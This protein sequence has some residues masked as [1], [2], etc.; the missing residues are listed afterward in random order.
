[1]VV[2]DGGSR[3][4]R[5]GDE[6]EGEA[7]SAHDCC[8]TAMRSALGAAENRRAVVVGVS[9][10]LSRGQQKAK[11]AL[12]QS[13]SES[14]TLLTRNSEL[15]KQIQALGNELKE[16]RKQAHRS[17]DLD[18]PQREETSPRPT[19]RSVGST[20][21]EMQ[22]IENQRLRENLLFFTAVKPRGT[23]SAAGMSLTMP[24]PPV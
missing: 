19:M 11:S 2:R 24:L 9:Q 14:S 4:T 16:S 18:A 20:S 10:V 3:E 5:D 12:A 21:V 1:M 6:K 7:P 23:R 8:M 13:Q 15:R 22:A 17:H